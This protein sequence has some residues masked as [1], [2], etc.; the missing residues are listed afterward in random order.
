MFDQYKSKILNQRQII[1]FLFSLAVLVVIIIHSGISNLISGIKKIDYALILPI[2]L[3]LF[4]S[5]L[6][7]VFRWGTILQGVGVDFKF[8]KLLKIFLGIFFVHQFSPQIGSEL[9]RAYALHK[10]NKQSFGI[11]SASV[12]Y[13]RL[14]DSISL[15]VIVIPLLIYSLGRIIFYN[16]SVII[17]SLSILFIML[18]LTTLKPDLGVKV[19]YFLTKSINYLPHKVSSKINKKI[20]KNLEPFFNT[21][22]TLKGSKK[23]IVLGILL[24]FF[25]WGLSYIQTYVIFL[26]IN[27][28]LDPLAVAIIYFIPLVISSFVFI[29]PKGPAN[30]LTIYGVCLLYGLTPE[31]SGLYIVVRKLIAVTFSLTVGWFCF[32]HVAVKTDTK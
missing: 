19:A 2:Y 31:I 9:Y 10:D 26:S 21:T 28:S 6:V 8:K 5:F 14:L 3:I 13:D 18:V 29:I 30:D 27:V 1:L 16:Y 7:K 17:L 32:T 24:S 4:S 23:V 25:A 15:L 12:L 11:S 20:D 22:D